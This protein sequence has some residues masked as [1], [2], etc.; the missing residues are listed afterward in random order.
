M[1]LS[2]WTRPDQLPEV[3]Q[4]A[5]VPNSVGIAHRPKCTWMSVD[6]K[7]DW[8]CVFV[9]LYFN[10]MKTNVVRTLHGALITSRSQVLLLQLLLGDLLLL[11]L[12]VLL[13]EGLL[14]LD[15]ADLDV[16]GAAHVRV[17][18]TVGPVGPPSHLGSAVDLMQEGKINI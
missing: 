2:I 15:E 16:T 8:I 10:T 4:Q 5:N 9:T 18:P 14:L 13:A 11:G 1:G 6:N 12:I 7:R 17:D 3:P